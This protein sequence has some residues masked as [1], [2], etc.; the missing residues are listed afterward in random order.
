[1]F[2]NPRHKKTVSAAHKVI[3]EMLATNPEFAKVGF[4]YV[5]TSRKDG[6][7]EVL[8]TLF[9]LGKAKR[10]CFTKIQHKR[11]AYYTRFEK[12]HSIPAD[13]LAEIKK[14]IGK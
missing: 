8:G 2:I 11:K 13:I 14:E 10:K 9:N 4:A 3:V 5:I 12:N 1:M 7:G 6:E